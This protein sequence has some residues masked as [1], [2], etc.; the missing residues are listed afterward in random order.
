VVKNHPWAPAA[1]IVVAL[2]IIGQIISP[3]F[4]SW[5]NINQILASAAILALAAVGQ[6][7]VMIAGNFGIDLSIGQM[8]SLTAVVA[9]VVMT[10]GAAYLPLAIAVVL[11]IGV[12]FGL[13]NG[14]LVA[15]VQLPALVVTLGTSV[16]AMGAIVAF[17][18]SGTP[19]GQVPPLLAAIT[20]SSVLGVRWVTILV[21]VIVG[22][23]AIA[24][25]R[26][27]FGRLLYLVGSSRE[28]ARLSGI[29]VRA[30]VLTA[31]AIA[32]GCG[33]IAGLFLL[34]YAGT[35]NLNLGGN[36]LLLSIAAAVIGGTSLAGGQGSVASSAIGALALQ[37]IT[38][39]LLTLGVPTSI[40]QVTTG[41]LLIILLLVNARI[42]KLRQ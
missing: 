28:A 2:L 22:L 23:I 39:F 13:L 15:L 21:I 42:P 6:S 40:Q 12:A 19:N 7:V 17:T 16:I 9:F 14:A 1:I 31:F 32:G 18:S 27:K 4:A 33:A 38:S 34:S 20:S 37:I 11:V 26:T 36:Y 3:G 25:A 5:G 30:V 29:N 35:A 10:G 41:L 8:M 24:L